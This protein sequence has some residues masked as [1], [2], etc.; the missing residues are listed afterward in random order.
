M[1]LFL[2]LGSLV[3]CSGTEQ[4]EPSPRSGREL[5]AS[6]DELFAELAAIP[7]DSTGLSQEAVQLNETIRR[8]IESIGPTKFLGEIGESYR[9]GG[10]GFSFALSKD[11]KLGIFSWYTKMDAS[12]NKIKNMA[13]YDQGDRLEVSSLSGMPII[14]GKVHQVETYKDEVL[15]MLHGK[16]Q[17]ENGDVFRLDAY[18]LRHGQ[19]EEAPA[20]PNNESSIAIARMV[21]ATD[22]SDPLGFRV[23]M[24][25]SRILVPNIPGKAL[26]AHA[27][28]F[29]G[30]K[31]V[32][33]S[34]LE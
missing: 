9:E 12:G 1:A 15:Y 16:D 18:T 34:E 19:L 32:P 30:R 13:V 10:H 23:V 29:N 26:K 2:S 22:P 25:G 3:G 5:I 14:Y 31:Y 11:K 28:A 33:E 7:L 6:L 24:N 21:R 20:F 17:N 27:L 8:K 4:G